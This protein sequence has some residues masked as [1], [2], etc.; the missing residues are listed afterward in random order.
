MMKAAEFISAS[1]VLIVFVTAFAAGARRLLGVRTSVLRTLLTGLVGIAGL[2][3]F[4]SVMQRPE[5]RGVLTGVQV[6]SALVVA[7]GFLA[8][9]EVVVPSGS[10]RPAAWLRSVRSRLDRGRRYSHISSIIVRHGL[11]PYL[12]GRGPGGR[13]R[14]GDQMAYPLRLALEEAGTTFVKLGQMLSTRDD[15]L[16]PAFVTELSRLQSQ[17]PP[18][19]W[20]E[21]EAVLREAYGRPVAEV[22]AQFDPEPLAAASVA[23]VHLARL[24]CGEPV[25]VKVQRPGIRPVVER[26]LEVICRLARMLEER[27]RWAAALGVVELAEAFAAS[28]HEELDFRTEAR[29]LAVIT[30]AWARRP[31]DPVVRLPSAYEELSGERVLVLERLPGRPIGAAYASLDDLG[32]DRADLAGSLLANM[33]QQIMVDGTFHA[34]PHPGNI[35]L[36]DDGGIG[37]VDFGSVG[38]VDARLQSGLRR[39]ISAVHRGNAAALCDALLEVVDRPDDLDEHGLERSLGRFMAV[40]FAPGSLPDIQV[41]T[42][43]FR[44]VAAHGLKIPPEVATVFRALATL[45][46]T[47]VR[48]RPGF[49]LVEQAQGMVR[50]QLAGGGPEAVRQAVG[51]ELAGALAVLRRLP[52]RLDRVTGAL[53]HGRLT[54]GVRMFAD[55]QDRAYLRTLLYDVLLTLLGATTGVMGTVL[56]NVRRGPMVTPSISLTELLGYHLLLVSAVLV[57]RVLFS[58]SRPRRP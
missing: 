57:M 13:G 25:V 50:K 21:V 56:L 9:S 2:A 52:R 42:A 34:D 47:L 43:L 32:L 33:L 36:L 8:V 38:R 17:V 6:G 10:C 3:V 37:L 58:A 4:S 22:F 40:H 46:G 12:R 39:F 14:S 26:D 29:N 53:E 49:N 31:Q 23:Q 7:M 55:P 45:E 27:T 11:R 16:P 19:P 1:L 30:R 28:V 24:H 44:L 20:T 18:A 35:L 48:I 41:F 5:Q 51:G 54:V 15:L